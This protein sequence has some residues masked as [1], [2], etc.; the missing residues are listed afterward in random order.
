MPEQ[1]NSNASPETPS[2]GT[3]DERQHL[4]V[5]LQLDE[6][7]NVTYV[8]GGK[9]QDPQTLMAILDEA[10]SKLLGLM[11]LQMIPTYLEGL[12]STPPPAT[13]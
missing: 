12:K 10:H 6:R 2:S 5:I 1:D 4:Q 8:D 3:S 11:V 7:G 13:S 9:I